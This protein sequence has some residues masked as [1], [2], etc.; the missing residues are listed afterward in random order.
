[1][2]CLMEKFETYNVKAAIKEVNPS[3]EDVFVNTIKSEK[4]K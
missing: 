2:K 4:R 1:M 3:L